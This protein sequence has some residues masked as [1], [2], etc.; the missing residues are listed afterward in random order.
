MA[1][2]D[3]EIALATRADIAG[4]L[5]LQAQNLR[6]QGGTLS[7]RFSREWFEAALADMP[8]IVARKAGA[9]SATWCRPRRR[10]R[11]TCRSSRLRSGPI[12]ARRMP[13]STA[14]FASQRASVAESA[15]RIDGGA[16]RAAARP[17]R[18]HLH[19]RDN[20]PSMRAHAKIGMRQVAEFI[21]DDAAIVV[22]VYP[23]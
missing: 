9:S 4:I 5:D 22:V 19:P 13:T 16:E 17:G 7:V 8:V 11:A 20:T 21:H 3:Y 10:R 18:H 15:G 12:R 14:P 23:G 2:F 6:E 1:S